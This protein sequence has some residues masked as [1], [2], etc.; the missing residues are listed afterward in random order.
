M[1]DKQLNNILPRTEE[2]IESVGRKMAA[3][4]SSFFDFLPPIFY[5]INHADTNIDED[6]K[7]QSTI[8]LLAFGFP[9]LQRRP[10]DLKRLQMKF[11]AAI[12]LL[13]CFLF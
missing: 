7:H 12:F 3:F 8:D 5:L 9:P 10:P 4:F 11:L 1:P 6:G 2:K 13:N